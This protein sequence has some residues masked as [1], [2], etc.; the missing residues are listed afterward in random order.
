VFT[1]ALYTSARDRVKVASNIQV[2]P[3]PELREEERVVVYRSLIRQLLA[4]TGIEDADSQVHHVF[5]ELI[6]AMFNVDEMLYFVAPEWWMPRPVPGKSP[7]R[8]PQEVGLEGVQRQDFEQQS[9][10]GWGGAGENRPDNYFI[11][12]DS[13]PAKLGSSL[14]WLLQLDGDNNRNAFL[15]A[16]WV[17]AVIPIRPGREWKALQWLS[18]AGVEGIDGLDAL[19]EASGSDERDRMIVALRKHTWDDPSIAG[20]YNALQPSALTILDAIRYLI[21]FIQEKSNIGA[22]KD[23]S[24]GCLPTDKVYEHG[25]DPLPGGFVAEPKIPFEIVDQWIEVVPTDQIVPVEVEYDPKT[26]MQK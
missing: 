20:R 23:D 16:P 22:T 3:F 4:N 24:I 12:E 14:G 7:H 26:G 25:F 19:Y 6:Q 9:V 5:S 1:Q 13:A 10:V 8:S 11:T 2:R 21:L 18:A 15:N 17:K